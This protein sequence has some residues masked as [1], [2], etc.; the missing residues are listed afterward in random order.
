MCCAQAHVFCFSCIKKVGC[1]PPFNHGES[2][3]LRPLLL[4]PCPTPVPSWLFSLLPMQWSETENTCPLCKSRFRTISKA[5]TSEQ[6]AFASSGKRKKLKAPAAETVK[7][8]RRDQGEMRAGEMHDGFFGGML[9]QHL[10]NLLRSRSDI[11]DH[12]GNLFELAA[13]DSESRGAAARARHRPSFAAFHAPPAPVLRRN[14]PGEPGADLAN[15]EVILDSDDEEQGDSPAAPRGMPDVVELLDSGDE[16]SPLASSSSGSA[17]GS[18]SSSSSSSS[19]ASSSS[20]S[21]STTTTTTM[22]PRSYSS[23]TA[24]QPRPQLV[25]PRVPAPIDHIWDVFS[26]WDD[27]E[28]DFDTEFGDY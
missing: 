8:A 18:G 11:Y 25:V 27:D 4:A 16:S 14:Q 2:C 1:P 10:S 9:H 15:A 20:S 21:S 28:D 5:S 17:S 13:R 24:T 7:V 3:L 26:A 19:Y 23:S 12:L 6:D 22:P